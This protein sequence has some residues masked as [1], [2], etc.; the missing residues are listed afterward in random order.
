MIDVTITSEKL[1]PRCN[2]WKVLKEDSLSDHMY[3]EFM[4]SN[5]LKDNS[6]QRSNW[7]YNIKK[8][9]RERFIEAMKSRIEEL[10][11][12]NMETLIQILE[13]SCNETIPKSRPQKGRKPMYWWSQEIADLRTICTQTR[14]IL[15]RSV[16][17]DDARKEEI[18][19]KY[20]K[21]RKEM[22]LAIKKAKER[23]W[24][25]L[26]NEVENNVWGSAYQIVKRKIA[27]TPLNMENDFKREVLKTL[28]PQ[29]GV[30]EWPIL[31]SVEVKEFTEEEVEQASRRMKNGKAPGPDRIPAEIIK[32]VV[33]EFKN[34]VCLAMNSVLKTGIIPKEWKTARIILIRK[35]GKDENDPRSYRPI[36]LLNTFGKLFEQLLVARINVELQEN[37]LSPAQF[38][39]RKGFSITGAIKKIVDIAQAEKKKTQKTRGYCALITID[40]C[41]AFNSASWQKIVSELERKKMP[42]YLRRVIMNYLTDRFI[43]DEA[44]G[45]EFPITAGVPQGSVIGP[46]LWNI[47]YDGI[48]NVKVPKSVSLI[49]YADD[50]AI[51]TV[52]KTEQ[53]LVRD[54]NAALK[55]VESWL[56]KNELAL[57]PEKSEAI[58]L[59]GRKKV[60]QNIKFELGEAVIS[61]TDTIKYLGVVLDKHLKFDH[62]V[63]YAAAKA[64]EVATKISRILPRVEGPSEKKRTLLCS[65]PLSIALYACQIWYPVIAIRRHEQVLERLHRALAIRVCRGY[66][67]ISSMSASVISRLPPI[68]LILKKRML[69]IEGKRK[70]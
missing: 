26:C 7:R 22:K 36:C 47:L 67:T 64:A 5:E 30:A 10:K 65:V 69:K 14:R 34:T 15:T 60:N 56:K 18:R 24:K 11:P 59:I 31:N 50:L 51:M 9:N 52:C 29:R 28:F 41:N 62:H 33:R 16:K 70:K 19:E 13:K 58:L 3:I 61:P 46:A 39:F 54:G 8:F 53:E 49:A 23:C 6:Q 66:R 42:A 40:V 68:K 32:L 63:R 21:V 38:G 4:I 57:A 55:V 2:G 45:M 27:P 20:R 43:E 17:K 48:L 35:G 37:N 44:D 1:S 12:Q 25:E